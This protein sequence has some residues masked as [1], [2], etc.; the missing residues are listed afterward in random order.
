MEKFN[1]FFRD[2]FM[3]TI[4]YDKENDIYKFVK[5]D[6]ERLFPP[7]FSSNPFTGTPKENITEEDAREF[8][9]DRVFPENRQLLDWILEILEIGA[10]NPWEI[11]VKC[12]GCHATDHYWIDSYGVTAFSNRARRLDEFKYRERKSTH[13]ELFLF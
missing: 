1:V 9:V 12:S 11:F 4:G 6:A 3:G 2:T 5:S 10:W 7:D 8:V 13:P